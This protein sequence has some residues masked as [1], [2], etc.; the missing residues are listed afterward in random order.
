MQ[1]TIDAAGRVV[2]PKSLRDR[3]GLTG[4]QTVEIHERDGFLQIGPAPTPVRLEAKDGV[5]TA[6][7]DRP[8]PVLDAETVRDT[9]ENV[10]R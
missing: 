1:T 2:I 5:L 6:V 3:L 10:R 7:P 4:G 9:L 8:L